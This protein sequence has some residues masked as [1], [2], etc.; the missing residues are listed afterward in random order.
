MTHRAAYPVC[1]FP[2]QVEVEFP[3]EVES[4]EGVAARPSCC[5][6]PRN[7][8]RDSPQWWDVHF[9]C[10]KWQVPP[11]IWGVNEIILQ[12]YLAQYLR[13]LESD[14]VLTKPLCLWPLTGVWLHLIAKLSLRLLRPVAWERCWDVRS[15]VP[16][17]H[18][19]VLHVLGCHVARVV[20][21]QWPGPS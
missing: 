18:G 19:S 2:V 21:Y 16:H 8:P 14:S 20:V 7:S 15:R 11:E 10:W 1:E 6:E 3:W 4:L 17:H 9:F 12:K 5:A 13:I